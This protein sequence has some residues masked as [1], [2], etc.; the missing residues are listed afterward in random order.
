[1]SNK[2]KRQSNASNS[3]T[4]RKTAN[5]APD[6]DKTKNASAAAFG[7]GNASKS[8]TRKSSDGKKGAEKKSA[9]TKKTNARNANAKKSSG[10][11]AKKRENVFKRLSNYLHGVRVEL[12]RVT[13]P[14]RQDV[15]RSS[16]IVV[17][18]LVFFGLLIFA[19]DSA[20][21]PLLTAYSGLVQ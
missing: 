11:G 1:M 13:W 8:V 16:V 19:I 21:V 15:A 4:Q 5:P 17:A 2:S 9:E 20:V 14:T 7:S 12:K 18:A 10:K 6:G 3:G